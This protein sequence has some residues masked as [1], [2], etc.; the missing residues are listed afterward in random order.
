MTSLTCKTCG[1]GQ[2]IFVKKGAELWKKN[3]QAKMCLFLSKNI[4]QSHMWA[5]V[6]CYSKGCNG[7]TFVKWSTELGIP[8]AS[9]ICRL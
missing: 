5:M 2:Q 9:V 7:G 4:F 3:T 1:F 6:P 8:E